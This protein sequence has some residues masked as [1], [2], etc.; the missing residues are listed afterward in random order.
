ML[1]VKKHI[2]PSHDFHSS[3]FSPTFI[4]IDYLQLSSREQ[5]IMD[6]RYENQI[7]PYINNNYKEGTQKKLI[8]VKVNWDFK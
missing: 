3:F 7:L 6:K 1:F 5:S 8:T 4:K 2:P